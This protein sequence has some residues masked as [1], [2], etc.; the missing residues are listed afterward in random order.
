MKID[1]RGRGVASSMLATAVRISR[2]ISGT[3]VVRLD[4]MSARAWAARNIYIRLGFRYVNP[5]PECEMKAK[6]NLILRRCNKL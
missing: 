1:H 4:D 5:E 6:S 2:R 3:L